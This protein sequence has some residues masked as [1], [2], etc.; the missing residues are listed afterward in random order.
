[1]TTFYG[2][3]KRNDGGKLE[4][5]SRVV[6]GFQGQERVLLGPYGHKG[7]SASI[8]KLRSKLKTKNAFAF[9][10]VRFSLFYHKTE[11]GLVLATVRFAVKKINGKRCPKNP[12]LQV[13]LLRP[14]KCQEPAGPCK[15]LV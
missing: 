8:V 15:T 3:F 13:Y 2:P 7:T 14:I 6:I 1:M 10:T 11:N 5:D 12:F 9:D 4:G